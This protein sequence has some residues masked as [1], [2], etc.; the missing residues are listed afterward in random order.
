MNDNQ[1]KEPPGGMIQAM[2]R[3]FSREQQ[4]KLLRPGYWY[5]KVDHPPGYA[6]VSV[7]EDT[8]DPKNKGNMLV[9]M[10]DHEGAI[11][12]S[13]FDFIGPVPAP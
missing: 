2:W 11:D 3:S 13:E 12:P 7:L 4:A 5:I 1:I 10:T 8:L 6:I 9:W